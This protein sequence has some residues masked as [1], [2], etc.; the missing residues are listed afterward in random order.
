MYRAGIVTL[1]DK[2]AAGEREDK[3]GAVIR[4]ILEAAGYEVAAQSLLPDEGEAL[5]KELIRLSDQV[6]CDLV[7]TTGGTG[8][9]RRDVTPE[10]TMAVAE[11]NAPGIAEA[12]RACSM[13]VTKRA[14]LSRGVSVIRGGTLII[15]LPGSP[16]A[17]RESLEYVLDTLPHGLDILS[18]RGGE[19][20][21]R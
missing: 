12:I 15:N 2:G 21:R 18:G 11:R 7:L 4:E 16:K 6:Q 17:V 8:F 9:S 19:C 3:S 14:M 13:T 5:K 1:S 10:A 20:A